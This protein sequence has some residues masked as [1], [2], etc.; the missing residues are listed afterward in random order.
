MGGKTPN[1]FKKKSRGAREAVHGGW[2]GKKVS[3]TY[4]HFMSH[5]SVG[6]HDGHQLV[7]QVRLG[8]KELR[9]E[10]LHHVF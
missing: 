5:Q 9:S 1:N 6:V 10:L 7:E 3:T 8:H 4:R 2:G